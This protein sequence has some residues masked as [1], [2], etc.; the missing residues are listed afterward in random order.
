MCRR[1]KDA[2]WH[3]TSY[4]IAYWCRWKTVRALK[5]NFGERRF[6]K[7][8]D[9][10]E[11][12]ARTH[13]VGPKPVQRKLC[14]MI[15][16]V[17]GFFGFFLELTGLNTSAYN[18]RSLSSSSGIQHVFLPSSSVGFHVRAINVPMCF[19]RRRCDRRAGG[20]SEAAL[21]G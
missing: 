12:A 5:R 3:L 17:R 18:F 7:K 8:G 4:D 6:D 21:A 2:I 16:G 9:E 10:I 15:N 14:A 13:C 1:H 20:V 11:A 19:C